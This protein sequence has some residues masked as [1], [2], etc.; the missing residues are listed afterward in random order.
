MILKLFQRGT[1]GTVEHALGQANLLAAHQRCACRVMDR[2][3]H[4]HLGLNLHSSTHKANHLQS[5]GQEGVE[6]IAFAITQRMKRQVNALFKLLRGSH[7]YRQ[8]YSHWRFVWIICTKNKSLQCNQEKSNQQTQTEKLSRGNL[9][10]RF[11]TVS[12]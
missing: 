6:Q 10:C 1:E 4:W 11:K 12:S 9:A 5:L 3:W 2:S 8:N 7:L